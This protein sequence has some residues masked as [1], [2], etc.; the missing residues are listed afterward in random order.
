MAAS[1]PELFIVD[2]ANMVAASRSA[3]AL[4]RTIKGARITSVN[5]GA[6]YGVDVGQIT[7]DDA[8]GI[9]VG[10][11]VFIGNERLKVT[12][13]AGNN[14]SVDRGEDGTDPAPIADNADVLATRD[15]D[16]GDGKVGFPRAQLATVA[17]LLD[18]EREEVALICGD[19]DPY[20]LR[21][22]QHGRSARAS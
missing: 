1:N 10:D 14:L 20:A 5:H 8:S 22:R 13:K 17:N 4:L 21:V 3:E 9:A 6:G 15:S 12:A 7:V 2:G 19:F 18:A 16:V 11:T